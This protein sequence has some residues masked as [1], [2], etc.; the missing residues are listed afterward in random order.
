MRK[1]PRILIRRLIP[2]FLIGV[3]ALSV[4]VLVAFSLG[5]STYHVTGQMVYTP[6]PSMGTKD[7]YEPPDLKTLL[8]MVKTPSNL[9]RLKDEFHLVEP[10]RLLDQLIEVDNPSLTNTIDLSLDWGDADQGQDILNR[11]M[12]IYAEEVAR[13]RRV[14]LAGYVD[15]MGNSVRITRR[16]RSAAAEAMRKF[17]AEVAI[18]DFTSGPKDL[19]DKIAFFEAALDRARADEVRYM[20]TTADS[21]RRLEETKKLDAAKAA[22]EA[23]EEAQQQSTTDIRNK[24]SRLMEQR[25]QEKYEKE[26][27]VQIDLKRAELDRAL[28]LYR[29]RMTTEQE[30]QELRG[31]LKRLYAKIEITPNVGRIDEEIAKLDDLIVPQKKTKKPKQ[32]PIITQLLV[33]EMQ[34]EQSLLHTQARIDH[35]KT[36]LALHR[37]RLQKLTQLFDEGESLNKEVEAVDQQLLTIEQQKSAFEQMLG[38]EPHEFTVTSPATHLL[39][40]PSSNKKKLAMMTLLAVGLLLAGPMLAWDFYQA[41]QADGAVLMSGYGLATISPPLETE[42]LI[43]RRQALNTRRWCD[44]VSLRLQQLAPHPG[45][46]VLLSHHRLVPLDAML[47]YATAGALS[48]RDERVCVVLAQTDPEAHSLFVAA[49][50]QPGR[51]DPSPA[52][53]FTGLTEYLSEE[54][55]SVDELIVRTP[56]RNVDVITAGMGPLETNRLATRRMDTLFEQLK[57]RYTMIMLIG[58]EFADT[59]GVEIVARQADGV[60]VCGEEDAAFAA[61]EEYTLSSLFELDAPMWGHVVRPN[62][63]PIEIAAQCERAAAA[64]AASLP[65]GAIEGDG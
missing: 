26:I 3:A 37:R 43:G 56:R 16:R 27:A 58:P 29:R 59:L 17:N 15:D 38:Y 6:L 52:G 39:N 24:Q 20:K 50:T 31:D 60:V 65:T 36:E 5:A 33:W 9:A 54:C 64:I 30:I 21:K 57:P 41:R 2:L 10:V 53:R 49:L 35:F 23:E 8:T 32:S 4:A 42:N 7:L 19:A 45:S 12:A 47:W 34:N 28:V 14:K 11:L 55:D 25:A 40:P 63:D 13:M 51:V 1:A 46:V 48:E 22:K 18:D 62:E 44:Q 61:A